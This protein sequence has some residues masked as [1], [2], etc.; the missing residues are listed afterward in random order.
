MASSL[1]EQ[2]LGLLELCTTPFSPNRDPRKSSAKSARLADIRFDVVQ[3]VHDEIEELTITDA[4][5]TAEAHFAEV[6]LEE[7]LGARHAATRSGRLRA[8]VCLPRDFR[9]HEAGKLRQWS[10]FAGRKVEAGE[11]DKP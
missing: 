3:I 11:V 9:L 10:G 5:P 4:P 6:V 2:G 7:A 1:A 8:G